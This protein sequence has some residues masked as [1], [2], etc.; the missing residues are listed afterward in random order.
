[1]NVKFPGTDGT[2]IIIY[3]SIA[4]AI[5]RIVIGIISDLPKVNNIVFQQVN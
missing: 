3:I 5:S 2:Q 4:T 1:M